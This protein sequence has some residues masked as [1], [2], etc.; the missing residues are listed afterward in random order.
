MVVTAQGFTKGRGLI[1]G[2]QNTS[3]P[4]TLSYQHG[5]CGITGISEKYFRKFWGTKG[6]R[7][8]KKKDTR[9]KFSL[10]HQL[11]RTVNPAKPLT[12]Q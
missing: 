5:P 8:A 4:H 2:L 6:N 3:R 7:S 1:T 9:G 12:R 10:Q 11:Q